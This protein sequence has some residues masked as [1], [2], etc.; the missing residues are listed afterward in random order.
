[1]LH[2]IYWLVFISGL[3]SSTILPGNSEAIF[4]IALIDTPELAIQLLLAVTVGNTIG[5]MI[6]WGM[7]RLVAIR[8]PAEQLTKP[9]HARALKTIRQWG[10]PA[11][12]LSWVPVIGDPLCIAAGWLKTTP[13]MS[14]IY[15]AV[16][17]LLRYAMLAWLIL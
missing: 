6:S 13:A 9:A 1:V 4:S 2:S 16:G 8:Y 10:S 17:K 15:I 12:L 14:F 11:L 3:L 5:G 7:G